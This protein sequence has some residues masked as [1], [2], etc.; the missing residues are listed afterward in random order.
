MKKKSK[1]RPSI[2]V[3]NDD[4]VYGAGLRPLAKALSSL[5]QVTVIVPEQERSAASHAITL[6]KPLR[7][8]HL[9][10]N[11]YLLSG[12]PADCVRFGVLTL[13]RGRVD[14]VVSGINHGPNLGADT[15]YSGTLGGA[16]EACRHGLT[17]VAFSLVDRG[18]G[19]F[20]TAALFACQLMAALLKQ[21]LPPQVCLNVNVPDR[22]A[23]RLRGVAVTRLGERI[24]DDRFAPRKDPR[25]RPYYWL[26]GAR[27][28]GVSH[29]GSD[30]TAVSNGK[31]SVTP[32]RLDMTALDVIGDLRA[33]SWTHWKG[34]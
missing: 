28:S 13:L 20:S 22:P 12:T 10:P 3:V 9:E 21:P 1:E 14:A 33:G 8:R 19:H 18:Q 25:G 27:A 24:Y 4:G 29:P 2:L 23:S 26:T 6:H 32:I 5:A 34:R 30:F 11:F 31:I 16:R 15:L 7:L 17:A